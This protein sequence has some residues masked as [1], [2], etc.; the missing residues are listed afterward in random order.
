MVHMLL[1]R[2]LGIVRLL[3]G[4]GQARVEDICLD[5]LARLRYLQVKL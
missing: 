2:Y 5:T 1:I 3:V 4:P